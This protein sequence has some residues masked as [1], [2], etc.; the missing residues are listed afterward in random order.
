VPPTIVRC[1]NCC[2]FSREIFVAAEVHTSEDEGAV[3]AEAEAAAVA[4]RIAALPPP[5]LPHFLTGEKG[6]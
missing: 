1:D 6:V 5:L 2:C 4:A 3:M